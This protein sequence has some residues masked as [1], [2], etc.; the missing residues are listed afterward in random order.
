MRYDEIRRGEGATSHSPVPAP[1]PSPLP[2]P[3]PLPL[4][5]P[6]PLASLSPPLRTQAGEPPIFE[7]IFNVVRNRDDA[8]TPVKRP[9]AFVQPLYRRA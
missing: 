8:A 2:L 6:L 9:A 4:P 3:L 7:K 1:L 5:H